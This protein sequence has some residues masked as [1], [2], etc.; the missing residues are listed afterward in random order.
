M[1]NRWVR[2]VML[3]GAL[4]GVNFAA[5]AACEAEIKNAGTW[6]GMTTS[7][8]EEYWA[9]RRKM[10]GARTLQ[11]NQFGIGEDMKEAVG[12]Y[13]QNPRAQAHLKVIIC[14]QQ[15][16]ISELNTSVK[17]PASQ[18]QAAQQQSQQLAAQNQP[19]GPKENC[20]ALFTAERRQRLSGP[21]YAQ[22]YTDCLGRIVARNKVQTAAPVV[23]PTTQDAQQQAQQKTHDPAAKAHECIA[24]DNAGSGNFGAFK[25]ICGYK[26]NFLTC[27]YKPRV[28]QGGFNWSADF[29]CEQQKFGLHTPD[30]GRS[31][32]AHNRNT[33]KVYWFACKAPA[34]PVDLT[35]VSG[36]GLSGRCN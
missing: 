34:S 27:N 9:G 23:A 14:L 15:D 28:I 18:T 20:E 2:C 17:P 19:T 13:S 16:A 21:L 4:L 7:Q 8:V 29:D 3:L 33:E 25:N 12:F 32:A 5:N 11:D 6:D 35:F 1:M 10:Y 22:E 36:Q 26:V 31:V 24:I 30:G